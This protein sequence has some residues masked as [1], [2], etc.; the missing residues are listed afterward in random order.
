MEN[1][2]RVLQIM[3]HHLQKGKKIASPI[4]ERRPEKYSWLFCEHS[5]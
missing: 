3:G 4:F 2:R 5:D 1:R